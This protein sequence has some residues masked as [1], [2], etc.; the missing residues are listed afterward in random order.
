M[1]GL[2]SSRDKNSCVGSIPARIQKRNP[3]DRW[4][5]LVSRDELRDVPCS[6][7]V[8]DTLVQTI[9]M[10]TAIEWPMSKTVEVKVLL[11]RGFRRYLDRILG[12]AKA[13]SV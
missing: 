7:V 11:D 1:T 2:S 5:A 13:E 8:E 10:F 9:S 6:D 4:V 12:N 3:W